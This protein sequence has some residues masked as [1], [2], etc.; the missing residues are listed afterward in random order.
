MLRRSA[1]DGRPGI[2]IARS[3]P[4][5][6]RTSES[7]LSRTE[8]VTAQPADE[9]SVSLW[10]KDVRRTHTEQSEHDRT[11]I[12]L[13]VLADQHHTRHIGPVGWVPPAQLSRRIVRLPFGFAES[14]SA[15][16]PCRCPNALRPRH[17]R[18]RRLHCVPIVA[19]RLGLRRTIRATRVHSGRG[20]VRWPRER[21]DASSLL[22][23]QP[24]IA[25]RI[26]PKGVLC[27]TIA[28]SVR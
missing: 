19:L 6:Q 28:V 1:S 5:E 20:A 21:A 4:A 18:E 25:A 17:V 7:N 3:A 23:S 16:P 9:L 22:A 13:A 14:A 12:R 26:P 15:T 10:P 27:N 24:L 8:A 2:G 11:S